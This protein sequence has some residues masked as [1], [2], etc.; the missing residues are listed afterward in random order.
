MFLLVSNEGSVFVSV[1]SG[2][3]WN[4]ANV[5]L[6]TA[7]S[8][9]TAVLSNDGQRVLLVSDEGSVF[10]SVDSGKTWNKA[11]VKLETAESIK[12]AVLSN[13]GQ[14]VLLVSDEGSVFVSID[15]A[16]SWNK[17]NVKLE[18]AELIKTAV[19]SNDGQR[20]L[21]VGYQGSVFVSV[22]GAKSW[23]K[24][25]VKLGA[26]EFI[27]T[28][29][30]S[31]DGQRVLLVSDAGSVFVSVDGAKSW[32]KANVKLETAE[33]IKIAV[34]S[35]DGQRVLLVSD[36]GSVFVSVDSGKTWNKADVE[37]NK[38]ETIITATLGSDGK[39]GLLT[40]NHGSVFVTQNGG[41]SWAKTQWD[42][43]VPALDYLV[44]VPL[45]Y[46]AHTAVAVDNEGIAYLLQAHPDIRDWKKWLLSEVENKLQENKLVRNS[47]IF[48]QIKAFL[49][50]VGT[51]GNGKRAADSDNKKQ[52]LTKSPPN[53]NRNSWF[54]ID[55]L[56][57][58]R[59]ATMTV[60]FFLVQLLV[61]L[62]Q[63]SMRLAN[64]WDS[65]ADAILL[66]EN[67]AAAK[68][69]RF[70]DLVQALAPDAYDFKPMP[71]SLFGWSLSRRN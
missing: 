31:N 1:D 45:D 18:T 5:K 6:E 52:E 25:N 71:R 49:A 33:S 43:Q 11:N 21:L 12:I 29:V 39:Q 8:I 36:E 63:Y 50:D 69:L 15:G 14:R 2:K 22:D 27:D 56:T 70:D 34:L 65:R 10:V 44:S 17:A 37:L 57:A 55:D 48:R 59:I 51:I 7:E 19:L 54:D 20:V 67:F 47:R 9:K 41:K 38:L 13:D 16:K 35:N 62:Y 28:A 68:A 66:D 53:N 40:G 23:N 64:F 58:M 26:T 30:L 61:R 46:G 3:T 24:A 42:S 60:L 32:N 4:K